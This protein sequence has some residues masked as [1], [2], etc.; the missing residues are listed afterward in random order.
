MFAGKMSGDDDDHA[1]R[2]VECQTNNVY[3]FWQPKAGLSSRH[4]EQLDTLTAMVDRYFGDTS[5]T[6]PLQ[7]QLTVVE[8]TVCHTAGHYGE[9]HDD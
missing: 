3:Y 1:Q 4:S 2:R 8:V 6:S 9:E 7:G 5:P